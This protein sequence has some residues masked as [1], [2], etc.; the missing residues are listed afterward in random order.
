MYIYVKYIY[1]FQLAKKAKND[2]APFVFD[3]FVH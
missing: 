2:Q 3:N 1:Y